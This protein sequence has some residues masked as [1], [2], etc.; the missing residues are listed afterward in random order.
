MGCHNCFAKNYDFVI[1]NTIEGISDP[2]SE[3]SLIDKIIEKRHTLLKLKPISSLERKPSKDE[4]RNEFI[5]DTNNEEKLC[6]YLKE[7]KN[8][9]IDEYQSILFLYFDA[10]SPEN[11]KIYTN[12]NFQSNIDKFGGMIEKMKNKE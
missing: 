12:E 10:L 7:L 5:K 4:T 9:N 8:S 1:M 2:I 6:Q 3:L 11:K